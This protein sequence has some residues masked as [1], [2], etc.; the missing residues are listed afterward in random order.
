VEGPERP[1]GRGKQT[2]VNF[3]GPAGAVSGKSA[4]GEPG[5]RMYSRE[6]GGFKRSPSPQWARRDSGEASKL[7]HNAGDT[8]GSAPDGSGGRREDRTFL[9]SMGTKARGRYN[10]ASP[11]G[12]WPRSALAEGAAGCFTHSEG[13]V[14][15]RARSCSPLNDNHV[16]QLVHHAWA[17]DD[18][19]PPYSPHKKACA[20]VEPTAESERARMRQNWEQRYCVEPAKQPRRR[21]GEHSPRPSPNP[22]IPREGI[23]PAYKAAIPRVNAKSCVQEEL[24]HQ[25]I[26]RR[27]AA[28][29]DRRLGHDGKFA[30]LCRQTSEMRLIQR[31]VAHNIKQCNQWSS[32]GMAAA[33]SRD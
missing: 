30:D 10:P 32:S 12:A 33:L 23:E 28:E 24:D 16:A 27:F 29:R 22:V 3:A 13:C 20:P 21:V 5:H 7:I 8:F 9:R 4:R 15:R 31:Q 2:G 1:N 17:K 11:R 18:L 14:S 19:A 26:E 25:G 6:E